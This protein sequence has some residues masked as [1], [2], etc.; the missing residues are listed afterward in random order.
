MQAEQGE[1]C[2]GTARRFGAHF[3]ACS[4]LPWNAGSQIQPRG[5]VGAGAVPCPPWGCCKAEL[6]RPCASHAVG[7]GG[8][9]EMRPA[10]PSV[11]SPH[12]FPACTCTL[13]RPAE[14]PQGR[15]RSRTYPWRDPGSS[16]A[17]GRL[18]HTSLPPVLVS[19]S[20]QS[21]DRDGQSI[22]QWESC[23]MRPSPALGSECCCHAKVP[24][25]TS[26]SLCLGQ[27]LMN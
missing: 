10:V 14:V 21:S 1:G 13:R 15:R 18:F 5:A 20:N 6:P 16:P 4:G 27:Q 3:P 12:S 8:N 24:A 23:T 9:V 7:V 19:I 2:C 26:Q 22:L 11:N 25:R 17:A